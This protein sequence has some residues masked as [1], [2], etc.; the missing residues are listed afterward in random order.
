MPNRVDRVSPVSE[1]SSSSSVRD[2]RV[3][4]VTKNMRWAYGVL[5][6]RLSHLS[7][8]CSVKVYFLCFQKC[9]SSLHPWKIFLFIIQ[10]WIYGV[11]IDV[12][13]CIPR[14]KNVNLHPYRKNGS[15]IWKLA[16]YIIFYVCNDLCGIIPKET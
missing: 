4:P 14:G 15:L 1:T 10:N 7:I 12:V 8:L 16:E 2:E 6:K 3:H 11:V 5:W 13:L 9:C